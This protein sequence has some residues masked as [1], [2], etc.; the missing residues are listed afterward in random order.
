MTSS[1]P[2]APSGRPPQQLRPAARTS[3]ALVAGLLAGLGAAPAAS[4]ASADPP[5]K[6][7]IAMACGGETF[8]A[9]SG[10]GGSAAWIASRDG[11]RLVFL[12]VTVSGTVSDADGTFL[13]T[14]S[15]ELGRH[16]GG[17]AADC[18]FA[19]AMTGKDGEVRNLAGEGRFLVRPA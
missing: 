7:E 14:F 5:G 15:Q 10:S 4:A 12:P 6:V 13:R 19:F 16:D 17:P 8:A 11:K 18:T 3:I 2:R 1:R 9:S